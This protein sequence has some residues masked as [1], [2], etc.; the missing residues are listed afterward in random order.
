MS[1]AER[2]DRRA[3]K[4]NGGG[5]WERGKGEWGV[6]ETKFSPPSIFPSLSRFF[7][8]HE[9]LEEG[10]NGNSTC[11]MSSR[12][13]YTCVQTDKRPGFGRYVGANSKRIFG[14]D[15]VDCRL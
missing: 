13:R 5:G 3:S 1:R 15:I 9:S 14:L 6:A 12:V 10:R 7:V 2:I 8:R 4:K 11:C